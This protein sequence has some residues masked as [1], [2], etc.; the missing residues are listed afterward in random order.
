[1]EQLTLDAVPETLLWNLYQRA[2]EARLPDGVL[3][4]PRASLVFDAVPR[5]FSA[6][7][8]RG[9]MIMSPATRPRRCRGG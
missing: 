8:L 4:D 9:R 3:H 2:N 5:W 1:M 6:R 7:T